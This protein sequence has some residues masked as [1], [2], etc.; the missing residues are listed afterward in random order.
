[1]A[2][3]QWVCVCV[4][5]RIV[6]VA[7]T[8]RPIATLPA[9]AFLTDIVT[10]LP[11]VATMVRVAVQVDTASVGSGEARSALAR[12]GVTVLV[13][14]TLVVATTTVARVTVGVGTEVTAR[15]E[16]RLA[17]A[18]ATD[19]PPEAAITLVVATAAMIRVGEDVDTLVRAADDTVA[20]AHA[21]ARD[22]G[23]AFGATLSTG[24][25][26]LH[27]TGELG[28]DIPTIDGTVG[29]RAGAVDARARLGAGV[30]TGAAVLC[31]GVEIADTCTGT[32]DGAIGARL[33]CPADARG[34]TT[35]GGVTVSTMFGVRS[36][37]GAH[38]TTVDLTLRT[39][40]DASD[41]R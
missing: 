27:L 37:L 41:A 6:A 10:P 25:A 19:T 34:S 28:A 5:A 39:G 9:I 21:T 8:S 3:V 1:M 35:A 7:D 18:V 11:D 13:I 22:T 26:I 17:L 14:P 20:G 4:C 12:P 32:L 23:R 2:A 29:A 33:T 40:T 16:A 30:S 38:I 15:G 24:A 31:V 36:E